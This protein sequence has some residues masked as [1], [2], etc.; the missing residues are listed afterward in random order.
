[1]PVSTK[2]AVFTYAMLAVGAAHPIDYTPI[3]DEIDGDSINTG[4]LGDLVTKIHSGL[5]QRMG[6]QP[7]LDVNIPDHSEHNVPRTRSMIPTDKIQAIYSEIVPVKRP[8]N[9]PRLFGAQA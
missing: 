7:M 5:K 4:K 6:T 8:P 9:K 1:M 2:R 3:P